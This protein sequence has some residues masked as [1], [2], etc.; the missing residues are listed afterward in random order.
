MPVTVEVEGLKELDAALEG[1][2][3]ATARAVMRRAL[4]KA[5]KPIAEAM[6]ALAPRSGRTG[7]ILAK[8]IKVSTKAPHDHET[9]KSA[10]G[11]VL[12]EGGSRSEARTEARN[13]NRENAFAEAFVGP[14]RRPY[15]HMQEFGTAKHDPQPY[16]RPGWEST[17]REAL[18][19]IKKQMW[20][21][22]EKTA[23][24]LAK[25]QAK[26]GG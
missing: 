10:F 19:I 13:V 9:G 4:V 8:S 6:R 18:E 22:I 15:A 16:A 25:R 1:M 11:R 24:R 3:K 2:K 21:E 23:R 20:I 12:R 17:K 7:D 5:G 26:L 14:D